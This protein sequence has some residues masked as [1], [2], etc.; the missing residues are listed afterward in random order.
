M[1]SLVFGLVAVNGCGGSTHPPTVPVRGTVNYNGEPLTN[2]TVFFS[3]VEPNEDRP[4]QASIGDDG[5][6][7]VSTFKQ[8][9]GV[10][11][12]TYAISITSSVSGSEKLERDRGTGIG[13]KSAI[14]LRY[15]DPKTSMLVEEIVAATEL[16]LELE[17]L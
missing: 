1:A 12:G 6:F 5:T 16:P 17:D 9:D 14:P 7:V 8:G 13:G 4:A 10:V 15:T 11:A 3:P 2:G